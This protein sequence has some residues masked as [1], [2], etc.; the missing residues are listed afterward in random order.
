MNTEDC[1]S[2]KPN[3]TTLNCFENF[4]LGR[5]WQNEPKIKAKS[6]VSTQIR[7]FQNIT[8]C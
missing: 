2:V 6:I 8:V 3:S 5:K 7:L 4:D 1:Q